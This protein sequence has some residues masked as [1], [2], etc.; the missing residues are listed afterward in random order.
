MIEELRN[1]SLPKWPQLL[2]SG[3]NVTVEQARD[4]IL[5]TDGFL[6][7]ISTYSGGNNHRFNQEYKRLSGLQRLSAAI[8]KY[9]NVKQGY[10]FTVEYRVNELLK[11]ELGVLQTNYVHNTW[12]SSCFIYGPYGW[13]HPDGTISYIDNVGKWPSITDIEDEWTTIAEAFPFLELNSTLMNGENQEVGITPVVNFFVKDGKVTLA[14]GDISVH[15]LETVNRSDESLVAM[16]SDRSEQG[17]DYDSIVY[18]ASNV[19][20]VADNIIENKLWEQF[21]D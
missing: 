8:S 19:R 12:A 21:K 10:G 17:L 11:S 20:E 6:T 2:T 5:R 16:L 1:R 7:D 4:I 3:V 15:K 18:Y 13:C 14:E 9:A